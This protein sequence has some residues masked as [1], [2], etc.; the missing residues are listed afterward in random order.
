MLTPA[1]TSSRMSSIP[2]VAGPRV[3]RILTF[4]SGVIFCALENQD[5]AEVVDVGAG[6]L[7]DDQGIQRLEIAVAIVV[8]QLVAG[9]HTAGGGAGVAVRGH[10]RAGVV[11]GAVDAIGVAGQ[12]V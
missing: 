2:S 10:D 6:R 9:A 5:G 4:L 1:C 12:G 11:F 8:V 7:S 3:A